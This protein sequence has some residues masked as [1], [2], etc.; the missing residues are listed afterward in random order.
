LVGTGS[1]RGLIAS[2]NMKQLGKYSLEEGWP[3]RCSSRRSYEQGSEGFGGYVGFP[4]ILSR[5]LSG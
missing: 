4:V 5:A 1:N 3:R 2:K